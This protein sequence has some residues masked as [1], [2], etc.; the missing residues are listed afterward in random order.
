[1]NDFGDVYDQ[2]WLDI[3][4][5]SDDTADWLAFVERHPQDIIDLDYN[6]GEDEYNLTR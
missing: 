2:E 6:G 3:L 1:M 5:I 4:D